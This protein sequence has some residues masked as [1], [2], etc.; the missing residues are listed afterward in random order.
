MIFTR[1]LYILDEVEYSFV[2]TM[3]Q[4][5]PLKE[6]YFWISEYYFTEYYEEAWEIVWRL[7]YDFYAVLNPKYES[8]IQEKYSEFAIE[9]LMYVIKQLHPLTI[10]YSVFLLFNKWL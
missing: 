3:I 7:Y 4:K 10:D 6:A 9:D 2:D 5:R 1:F 8:V